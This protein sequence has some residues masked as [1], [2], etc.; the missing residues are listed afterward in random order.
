MPDAQSLVGQ[1]I[2]H[3]R[4]VE[5]LGAGGM[6]VVYKAQD[7]KL[8]RTVALKFLPHDVTVDA[9]D[10]E[11][12][13][14]EARS[15]SILDHENIGVIHGLEEGPDGQLF[16]VMAYYEG[17]TLQKKLRHGGLPVG[18]GMQ[19]AIQVA[20]GLAAAHA[21][22]IVHRDIK[23]SNI[24]ITPTGTAKIVDFGLARA[25][26]TASMTQSMSVSGTP[27]YMSPEQ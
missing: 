25:A 22:K 23:P 8:E 4:I 16:I 18:E 7:L 24:V 21:R 19:L 5:K 3:Y 17:E 13:L 15:A 6:G 27:V 10:K 11:K 2:A 1:T 26:A 12:L 14:R 20:K 9:E